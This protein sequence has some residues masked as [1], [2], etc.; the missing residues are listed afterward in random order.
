MSKTAILAAV[1]VA[2][3]LTITAAGAQTLQRQALAP[4]AIAHSA[5]PAQ[6]PFAALRETLFHGA[7]RQDGS[8]GTLSYPFGVAVDVSGNVYVTQIFSGV[9]VYNVRHALAASITTNVSEPSGVAIGFQGTVYVANEGTNDIT[10]YAPGSYTQTGTITDPALTNPISLYVDADDTAWVLD[11]NGY[12]HG[13]MSDGTVLTPTYSGGTVLGPWGS[14][15]TVWGVP[16]P[17][18]GW[19]E[20]WE[21]RS[22]AVRFNPFFGNGFS[23]TA[24]TGGEA[25]DQ[26]G[27]QYAT[28]IN[29]NQIIIWS[30]DG[31]RQVGAIPLPATGYG[32]AV[33]TARNRVYVALTTLN[34]VACYATKYPYKSCGLIK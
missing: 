33:D 24:Y 25:Q 29:G 13:Y 2:A 9:N 16:D 21:A 28:D 4:G 5:S 1:L 32:V 19:D 26:F 15:V 23:G 30:T 11:V 3:S 17:N 31:V 12:T 8:A 27:Q 18:G 14:N 20:N 22:Q 10:V 34:E 7:A 6:S